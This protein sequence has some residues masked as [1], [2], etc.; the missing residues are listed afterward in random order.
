MYSGLGAPGPRTKINVTET[1]STNLWLLIKQAIAGALALDV[2]LLVPIVAG[3]IIGPART[4]VLGLLVGYSVGPALRLFT[5]AFEHRPDAARLTWISCVILGVAAGAAAMD[6]SWQRVTRGAEHLRAFVLQVAE[7]YAWPTFVLVAVL[8]AV[9][10]LRKAVWPMLLA[11][12]ALLIGLGAA[13][14][15]GVAWLGIQGQDWQ[16]G[17]L[18]R[19]WIDLRWQFLPLLGPWLIFAAVLALRLTAEILYG[20]STPV[21]FMPA[22]TGNVRFWDVLFPGLIGPPD[23][24]TPENAPVADVVEYWIHL[25]GDKPDA[26]LLQVPRPLKDP[27]KYGQYLRATLIAEDTDKAAGATLSERGALSF[28]YTTRQWR[29]KKR[30]LRAVLIARG[31]AEDL[32]N[33]GARYTDKGLSWAAQEVARLLGPQAVPEQYREYL[34]KGSRND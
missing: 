19:A 33:Q 32:G 29:H 3:L 21:Q 11:I 7:P 9:G 2:F 24:E 22:E 18:G 34:P 26:E 23:T 14:Y 12:A 28:G 31:Y 17:L 20:T 5:N 30:G 10:V 25:P 1:E 16:A 27:E 13:Y 15:N 6:P 4:I 8:L